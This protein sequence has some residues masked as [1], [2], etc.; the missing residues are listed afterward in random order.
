[1]KYV[2][3]AGMQDIANDFPWLMNIYDV[4]T[5]NGMISVEIFVALLVA[6]AV[7]IAVLLIRRK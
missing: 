7:A 4:V 1:M 5:V 3:A 2:A 6:V